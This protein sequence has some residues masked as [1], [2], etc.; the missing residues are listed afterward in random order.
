MSNA[1]KSGSLLQGGRYKIQSVLGQGGFGITYMAEQTGLDRKVAIKEFFMKDRCERTGETTLVKGSTGAT[2]AMVSRFREKFLKEARNIARFTHPNIVRIHDIFEENG[3]A[4]YVMEYAPCGSLSDKVRREGPMPES[5]ATRYIKQ[6]ASA[7][8]Y[9]HRQ[10]V[11]HLDVKPG[12]IMLNVHDES[13]LID[14]GLSKQYDAASGGQTSTTPVG[15]SEGYAPME[16][17][18]MGGVSSF[19]PETDVYA[20]GATFFYLLTGQRPP[21][22]SDVMEDGIPEGELVTRRVSQSVIAAISKAM[23]PRKRDR[24][25]SMQEFINAIASDGENTVLVSEPEET[26]ISKA[27]EEKIKSFTVKGVSFDMIKVKGGTFNMG[28]TP[29]QEYPDYNEKPVHKVTLDDYWIGETQVTQALWKAVM[30][31]TLTQIASYNNGSTW[32]VGDN[33]PMYYISW[34]DCQEFVKKLNAL[35]G[36]HFRLPTE[37]EWEFAARGGTKSR[38]YQYSGSNNLGDVAWY[39]ENSGDRRN[40]GSWGDE[41]AMSNHNR[42]HP[43]ATKAPNE[44]GI[45]DMSGNVGEWCQDRDGSYSSSSQTNP[46]GPSSGSHRVCRGGSWYSTA[47]GCRSAFRGN[48]YQS[49]YG[50]TLGVRLALSQ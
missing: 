17:Y 30:G 36:Q 16:Q 14:F 20:L 6:I 11:N 37:A 50:C 26:V 24:F 45:Y 5:V 13:I 8:D 29:E 3:T 38:G 10:N 2:N 40:S 34:N 46:T 44:L 25:R 7:L 32:G 39:W 19:T 35:T 33:N 47:G 48:N 12:N 28:A 4:Y 18:K 23:E 49:I 41:R 43:V 1:L 42:T 27:V 22:A 9:I 31:K 21:S 15:I